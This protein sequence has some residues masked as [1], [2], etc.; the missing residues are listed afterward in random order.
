ME[1]K[2]RTLINWGKFGMNAAHL[3]DGHLPGWLE[4]G[5]VEVDA[6]IAND[7]ALIEGFLVGKVCGIDGL[8]AGDESALLLEICVD[9]LL[10]EIV[11]LIVAAFVPRM[12]AYNGF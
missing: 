7:Q 1:S 12:D 10:R 8:E 11:E 4:A 2:G 3:I 5:A 6:Q 9:G